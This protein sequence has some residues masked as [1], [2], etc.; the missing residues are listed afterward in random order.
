MQPGRARTSGLGVPPLLLA[1]WVGWVT[2]VRP[3]HE[4]QF[5]VSRPLSTLRAHM[6]AVSTAPWRLFT[7]V[8]AWYVLCVPCAV[9]R[10][11]W[12]PFSGVPAWCV[13]LHY[14]VSWATWLLFT[15]LLARCVV[16]RVW[17]HG[18]L[19]SCAPVCSFGVVCCVCG[20]L[21]HVAGVHRCARSACCVGCVVS[22]APWLLF[23]GM[24]ACVLCCVCRVMGPGSCSLVCSLGVSRCV[25][26]VLGHMAPVQQCAC[27]VSCVVCALSWATWLLFTG[28][29]APCIVLCV[30]CPEP[31]GS[32]SPACSLGVLCCVFCARCPGRL[33]S[34]SP[35]CALGVLCCVCGASLRGAHSS[36]RMAPFRSRQGLSTFRACTRP[37]GRRLLPSR[38]G[39]GM[40]PGAHS[41]IRMAAV[42]WPAAAGLAAGCAHVHPDG[43]WCCLAPVRVPWFVACCARCPGLRHLVAIIAWH[44][45]LCLGCGR[46]R[47]SLA[48]LVAPRRVP[49]LVWFGRSRCSGRLSRRRGAFPHP[50]DLRPRLYW[51]AAGGTQRPAK[52]WA[53]CGCRWPPPS[54]LW[55]I[56]GARN[57]RTRRATR[58]TC[59]TRTS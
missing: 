5:I 6:C 16:L 34:Y 27:S 37:S 45:F 53:H 50:G 29:H 7:G 30:R 40:L 23:T 51:A 44:L 41:S 17:C 36:F 13:V 43:G 2:P 8:R 33:G 11:A 14:A 3:N 35:V 31:H 52:K 54:G 56:L 58:Y 39:L 12:L 21:G 48:C 9:S 47:A 1:R 49:S 28:V 38:Q 59:S 25:C 24:L 18:P 4:V 46:R 20:V 42:P 19:G 57:T 22:W 15:G 55:Q 26:G 32:C 10:A